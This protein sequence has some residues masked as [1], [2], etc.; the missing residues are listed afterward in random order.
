MVSKHLSY[1][2]QLH[3]SSC[4]NL[5]VPS[6]PTWHHISPD[7]QHYTLKTCLSI[8]DTN[9][10]FHRIKSWI[11][12]D[13]D[14][15]MNALYNICYGYLILMIWTETRTALYKDLWSIVLEFS[16]VGTY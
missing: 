2:P 5:L 14:P 4:S 1:H 13:L 12:G 10:L 16:T 3:T 15:C 9:V 7:K 11:L 8:A 6:R